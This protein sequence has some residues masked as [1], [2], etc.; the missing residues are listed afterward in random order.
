M[1]KQVVGAP[2]YFPTIWKYITLWFEPTT[3][4][5]MLVL[6]KNEGAGVLRQELGL[7]NVPKRFG[8]DLDWEFGSFPNLSPDA[9][10]LNEHLVNNWVEGPLRFIDEP[11][12]RLRIVAVGS[13]DGQ[14]RRKELQVII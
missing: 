8:G 7:A 14:L 9:E 10:S 6:S 13:K 4:R 2:S 12:G 3:T 11:G 1:L 5:K